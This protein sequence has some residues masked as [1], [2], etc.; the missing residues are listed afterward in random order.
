[1]PYYIKKQRHQKE[2]RERSESAK[3]IDKLDRVFSLYIR[4]RD[5]KEFNFQAFRCIS[6]GQIKPFSQMDC[7]HFFSRRHM[8][9]RFSELN[10]SGECRA[11]NRFSADHLHGY[12]VNLKKKIGEQKFALLE[13]QA[14]STKKWHPFELEQMIQYYKDQIE[15]LKQ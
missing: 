14:H 6:C 11:C 4:L 13:A 10:A 12:E 2:K 3:L 8:A 15:K 9:T 5:S 1:M 7:G